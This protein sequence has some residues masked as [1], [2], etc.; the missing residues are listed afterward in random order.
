M[1]SSSTISMNERLDNEDLCL[2]YKQQNRLQ[3]TDFLTAKSAA[4]IYDALLNQ[5]QWNLVWNNNGV[6]TDM[7]YEV[8]SKWSNEQKETLNQVIFSQAQTSFQYFYA[9]IPIYDLYQNKSLPGHF[10]NQIYEFINSEEVL[11]FAR[12]ITSDQRISYADI[13]ATKFTQGHF[14]S[15]H[16][17]AVDGKK[18]IAAYVINLTPI[19]QVDWGG[20]L[21]F[22]QNGTYSAEALFPKF[23]A[24]NIFTIPQAHLVSMVTPFAQADRYS[25]TGWFRY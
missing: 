10:F 6:H 19:W 25:L 3:V 17:D 23:N 14:L 16:D 12:N 1:N 22:S 18:R 20:A 7:D 13:Q 15:E 2:Q 8:V 11:N 21:V 4:L 9:A 5:A 24:I